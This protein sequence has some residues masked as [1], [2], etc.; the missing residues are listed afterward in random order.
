[1]V[2][3]KISEFPVATDLTSAEIAGQQDSITKKFP[4]DLFD[5]RYLSTL[6]SGT[7]GQ[8]LS[9]VSGM[10]TWVDNV[11]YA[12]EDWVPFVSFGGGVVD[13]T[14]S[15]QTGAYIRIGDLVFARFRLDFTAKGTSTG[16]ALLE[17]LPFS[18]GAV[19]GIFIIDFYDDMTL[20]NPGILGHPNSGTSIA[21]RNPGL[22]TLSGL[23]DASFG[24]TSTLIGGVVYETSA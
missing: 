3:V 16:N 24:N 12:E 4:V 5:D 23:T 21:L 10:A 15:Q 14:Y 2:D 17:G 13:Q 1:M 20:T 19:G 11:G 6:E 22:V 7:E 8:I 18:I 9:F